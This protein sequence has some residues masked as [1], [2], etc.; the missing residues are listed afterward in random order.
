M[1][2]LSLAFTDW[3]NHP[4]TP[5]TPGAADFNRIQDDIRFLAAPPT[6]SAYRSFDQAVNHSTP[7]PVRFDVTVLDRDDMH[8]TGGDVASRITI[9]T[10]GW[11]AIYGAVV[12]EAP[13]NGAAPV[14]W[15]SLRVQRDGETTLARVEQPP[16]PQANL[17][18]GQ[19]VEA[20]YPFFAGQY[21]E[22]ILEHSQGSTLSIR[23]GG[24]TGARL[25][26]RWVSTLT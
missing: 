13:P 21:I 17:P 1:A 11:Y 20:F 15:R 9:N 12:W 4:G 26:A 2:D 19:Q 7:T 22:L 24:A 16:M 8:S 14:G 18:G 6:A 3:V 23:G 10:P 25:Q 5:S